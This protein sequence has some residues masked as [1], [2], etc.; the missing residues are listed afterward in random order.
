[1][2]S[3]RMAGMLLSRV[4]AL[5]AQPAADVDSDVLTQREREIV[6]LISEGMSNKLIARSLGIQNAT[7]KNHIHSILGKL[8]V[9]RRG[10]VAAQL[11]RGHINGLEDVAL[12]KLPADIPVS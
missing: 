2:C 1:V 9:S 4:R 7:V 6:L 11:R 10:E 12:A 8:R 3:P 5:A